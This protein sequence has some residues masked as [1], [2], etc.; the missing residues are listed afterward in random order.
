MRVI[1]GRLGGLT[2]DSPSGHKTHPMSEKV[3]GALFNALGDISG[4]TIL[5]AFAGSGALSIEAISRGADQAVAIDSDRNAQ[6]VIDE[7]TKVLGISDQVKLIRASAVAWLSTT[8]QSFDVVLCDP[9]Y[10]HVQRQLLADLA[11][12]VKPGGLLVLSL[13]PERPPSM[14]ADL[15]LLTSK[16]HGDA[17]LHFYRRVV[18][19]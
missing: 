4:L 18:I 9:P 14:P 12:R 6:R 17:I 16:Q 7:N 2:F 19:N 3:R 13:P 11:G 8:E 15:E 5:D 1:A 10:D